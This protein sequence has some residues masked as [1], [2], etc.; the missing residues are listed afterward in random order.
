MKSTKNHHAVL[1]Q[2]PK[3]S[4]TPIAP[5]L[6]TYA[7]TCKKAFAFFIKPEISNKNFKKVF[8]RTDF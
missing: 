6:D 4:N 1:V 7:N 5:P 3:G 8:Q 2:A